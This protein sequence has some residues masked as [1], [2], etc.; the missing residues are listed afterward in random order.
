MHGKK[1]KDCCNM[2]MLITTILL[3]LLPAPGWSDTWHC[4][5]IRDVLVGPPY[6]I[7][8]EETSLEFKVGVENKLISILGEDGEDFICATQDCKQP[9]GKT[10]FLLKGDNTDNTFILSSVGAAVGLRATYSITSRPSV[11]ET[12]IRMGVCTADT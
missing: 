11:G 4:K 9:L 8:Y 1:N 3:S 12:M 7:D 10:D 6:F 2:K 5:Q